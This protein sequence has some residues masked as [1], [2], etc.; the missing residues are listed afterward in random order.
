MV[1]AQNC[2][3]IVLTHSVLP[4]TDDCSDLV[5]QLHVRIRPTWPV[6]LKKKNS[7]ALSTGGSFCCI[8][9]EDS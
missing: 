7:L 4:V 5:I 6:Q 8:S 9:K 1:I 2:P 3:K